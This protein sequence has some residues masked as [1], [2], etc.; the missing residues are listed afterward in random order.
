MADEPAPLLRV[1]QA[2]CPAAALAA[3]AERL[4]LDP[5][6]HRLCAPGLDGVPVVWPDAA[7]LA[8][9]AADIVVAA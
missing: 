9:W 2:P 6:R 3:L 5:T 7:R 4:G 1:A 8:R